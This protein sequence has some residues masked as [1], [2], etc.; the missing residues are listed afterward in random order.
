MWNSKCAKFRRN[1]IKY[2]QSQYITRG[3]YQII[4]WWVRKERGWGKYQKGWEWIER[5]IV[6][7]WKGGISSW[8][9]WLFDF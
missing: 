8:Y 4:R 2:T 7:W 9:K 6:G 5:G 1:L 3:W